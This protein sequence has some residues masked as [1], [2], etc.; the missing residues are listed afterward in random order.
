MERRSWAVGPESCFVA[1]PMRG[2]SVISNLP[3]VDIALATY[4]GERFLAP[5][6]YSI[7]EQSHKNV[8]LVVSDDGSTDH[9]I[10]IL[11]HY[12]DKLDIRLIGSVRSGVVRNFERALSACDA[13]YIL[14]A[15]QDDIWRSDKIEKLVSKALEIEAKEGA[16]CPVLVYSDLALVGEARDI[17]APSFFAATLKSARARTLPDFAL[18]NHAPGCSTLLNRSLL[19]LALPFPEVTIHDW[20]I[21]ILAATAGSVGYFPESLIDYRQHGGNAIGVGGAVGGHINKA[22]DAIT[23]PWAFVKARMAL[24]EERTSI[25]R[26]QLL[27]LQERLDQRGYSDPSSAARELTQLGFLG[28]CRTFARRQTG[29]R[30]L[31][32]L[33]TLLFLDRL[34]RSAPANI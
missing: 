28:L 6:L 13:G 26:E 1:S 2:T 11:E 29:L 32:L 23:R 27:A 14:L 9:T 4:N 19:D 33:F 21:N 24:A 34:N 17:I 8:R 3:R 12:R 15:D 30:R 31:D 25:A 10:R 7:A 20:W 5:L 18:D 16:D 22:K